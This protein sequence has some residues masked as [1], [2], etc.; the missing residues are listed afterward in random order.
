VPRA[1]LLHRLDLLTK[2]IKLVL[3]HDFMW[4][5]NL[6]ELL[7]NIIVNPNSSCFCYYIFVQFFTFYS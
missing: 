3:V 2:I 6:I 1:P 7:L 5:N 4:R